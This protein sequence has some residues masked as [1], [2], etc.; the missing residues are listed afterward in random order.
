MIPVLALI[1]A[2]MFSGAA[3]YVLVAEHPARGVL[4]PRDQLAQ[5]K[6]S[7]ARGAVMQASLALLAAVLGIVAGLA[8]GPASLASS[9]LW[10]AGGGFML[11][12]IVW[13]FALMWTLN[14]RIKATPLDQAS[15]ETV[16]ML[17]RWGHLHGGR[18]A[19]GV[20]GLLCYAIALVGLPGFSAT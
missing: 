10:L 4:A 17:R 16:A 14:G 12:A 19:L 13:T 15:D 7:Y 9:W 8:Q 11:G 20:A 2:A 1:A 3:I 18:T 5:W 6:P